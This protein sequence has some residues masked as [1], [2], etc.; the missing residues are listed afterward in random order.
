MD[1]NDK[2][3][4]FSD[5]WFWETYGPLMFDPQR[6]AETPREVDAIIKMTGL[7]RGARI[8]D[9]CCGMGRHT[10]ELASRGYNLTGIDLS[11]G[12]LNKASDRAMKEGLSIEWNHMN[13]MDLKRENEFDGIINMFTSFGY[14]DDPDDDVRM[15]EKLHAALKPE[16]VLFMEMWGKEVLARDFEERVWFEREGV[17]ILLEYGIDLNW[18]E[19]R[20]RWL[21]YRDNK[22]TEYTF[23]HRIFSAAEMAR[24]LGEAGFPI[25]DI[26]GGFDGR[27]YD[28]QAQRLILVA[29]K[30][31]A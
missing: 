21:F 2:E 11:K 13:V 29:R 27:I 16:G 19:L 26:Y 9:C 8:L 14:F 4:W 30:G 24:L 22:M 5:E 25:V 17:T 12:Y 23:S 20:N 18:T 10:M 3:P 7:A 31:I 15:L 1:K 6:M 28:N